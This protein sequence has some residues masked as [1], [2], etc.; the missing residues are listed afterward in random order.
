VARKRKKNE[1]G[2]GDVTTPLRLN[3]ESSSTSP[4]TSMQQSPSS[5]IITHAYVDDGGM[6]CITSS[7]IHAFIFPS[8]PSSS[9][10]YVPIHITYQPSLPFSLTHQSYFPPAQLN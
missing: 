2:G 8:F 7:T 10:N 6:L 9:S 3:P 5:T 1:E 4:Y